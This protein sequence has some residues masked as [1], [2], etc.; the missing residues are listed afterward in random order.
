[1]IMKEWKWYLKMMIK[2][3]KYIWRLKMIFCTTDAESIF[4]HRFENQFS[5]TLCLPSLCYNN[6]VLLRWNLIAMVSSQIWSDQADI[7]FAVMRTI[8]IDKYYRLPS[9]WIVCWHLLTIS[10]NLI[11]ILCDYVVIERNHQHYSIVSTNK[12]LFNYTIHIK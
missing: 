12:V 1:M 9:S 4:I 11:W 2:E 7:A 8:C 3:W 10:C 6:R 5:S